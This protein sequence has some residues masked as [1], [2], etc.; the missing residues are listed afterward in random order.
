M[1]TE[2]ILFVQDRT[3]STNFYRAVLGVEPVLDVDGMTQFAL[4]ADSRLG[5][6][7]LSGAKK[8]IPNAFSKEDLNKSVRSELY[9]RVDDPQAYYSRA[10][11]NG[12][13]E[14][15]KLQPRNWGDEAAYCQDIDGHILV[16]ARMLKP[17]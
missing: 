3:L 13:S 10:I 5:L 16:F 2:I 7:P 4:G 12:A 15:S 9:L 6:M 17:N 11:Q 1:E 14:L 8:I